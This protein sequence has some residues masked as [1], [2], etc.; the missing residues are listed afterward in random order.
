MAF[1]SSAMMGPDTSLDPARSAPEEAH[2]K[3]LRIREGGLLGGLARV[4]DL[5]Q[6][7]PARVFWA[8]LALHVAMWAL[9]P[10]ALLRNPALDVVEGVTFGQHWEVLYWKHPPLPWLIVDS[11]RRGF[12]PR[13][14]PLLI[15]AQL[16]SGLALWAIWRLAR[17]ILPPLP[18]LV[19]VVLLEGSRSFTYGSEAL[20]HD[21]ISLPFWALAAWFFWR[22]V[23]DGNRRDWIVCGF[24]FGLG[25]YAKYSI[26]L[27][28]LTCGLFLIAEPAA[29]RRL[30]S[31]G[32]WL[33]AGV[34]LLIVAPQ[35]WALASRPVQP[36]EF[37]Q[38]HA[39]RMV[40]AWDRLSLPADFLGN[41]FLH[42]APL[43]ALALLAIGGSAGDPGSL[44]RIDGVA[45]RYVTAI[46]LGPA[47]LA[48]VGAAVAGYGLRWSWGASFWNF[49][50]LAAIVLLGPSVD[51]TGLRRLIL[52]LPVVVVLSAGSIA[53]REVGV[54]AS[55]DGPRT[56]FAGAELARQ[57]EARWAAHTTRPLAF[58]VGDFW[59]A[60][61]VSFHL[62]ERPYVF[63]D[64]DSR[65]TPWIDPA[66]VRRAGA[67]IIWPHPDRRGDELP[68]QYARLFPEA[69]VEPP[70]RLVVSTVPRPIRRA[71]GVAVV[72]PR[73]DATGSKSS[74][75][76]HPQ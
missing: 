34:F 69:Q 57:V 76:V 11:L 70:I 37:A 9:L 36:F 15:A 62:R 49:A 71:F 29:R 59:L 1:S 47:A 46:A 63:V 24:W 48:V 45:R 2:G 64:A 17:E 6:R 66:E 5:V 73:D 28:L 42:L 18:A 44:S 16:V 12:G 19:S 41:Q 22:S 61:N 51:R 8:F 38:S 54:D 23:R 60:G 13:L 72:P 20:N 67:V 39:T 33:A 10:I 56:Q 43:I 58:V 3:P 25:A 35:L 74:P 68:E 30:W 14:W 52:A 32:P 65:Q 75:Q 50:G 21:L 27:L 31:S 40:T 26:G 53:L 55:V 4:T 7:R